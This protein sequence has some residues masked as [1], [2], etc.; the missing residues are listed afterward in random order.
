MRFSCPSMSRNDL[1]LYAQHIR[2]TL[3]LQNVPR[4]PAI[5]FL[6]TLPKLLDDDSLYYDYVDDKEWN[7]N[8]NI[9]AYYDFEENC[10]K[11][12]ES[13]YIGAYTGN[14]RDRMTI[15]HE[16]CHVLLLRHSHMINSY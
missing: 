15:T 9:H 7:N 5:E 4:F 11:V 3:R 1:R 12:K 6:E 13:V 2:E 16:C 14:G 8:T 10:I